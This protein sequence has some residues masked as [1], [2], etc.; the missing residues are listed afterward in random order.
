MKLRGIT[1]MKKFSSYAFV[2]V[3]SLGAAAVLA[4]SGQTPAPVQGSQARGS[5]P[6]G[7]QPQLAA[8]GAFRDGFY[9]GRLAAEGGQ[10]M[11]PSIGRWSTA[12]D[13]SMFS[14]GYRRGYDESNRAAADADLAQSTD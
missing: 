10:P 7:S 2:I 3:L 11:R 6:Q 1:I 9:L 12:Q 8:D 14:A 4:N 5:R 13:R